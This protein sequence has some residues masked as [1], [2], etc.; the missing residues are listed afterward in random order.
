MT[1]CLPYTELPLASLY[2]LARDFCLIAYTGD[3]NRH[4]KLILI[5]QPMF[6]SLADPIMV[7]IKSRRYHSCRHCSNI[8]L[9]QFF[10]SNSVRMSSND[11]VFRTSMLLGVM[12]W[13]RWKFWAYRESPIDS[14]HSSTFPCH[15]KLINLY[16]WMLN[17]FGIL[18][19]RCM[20]ACSWKLKQVHVCGSNSVVLL[21]LCTKFVVVNR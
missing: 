8:E 11:I 12:M 5:F 15:N 14:N 13:A 2:S 6:Y 17:N 16:F 21:L 7:L 4:S 20:C 10:M 18:L 9:T 1:V 3:Q 19:R